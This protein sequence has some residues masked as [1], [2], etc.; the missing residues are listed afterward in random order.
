[1]NTKELV[2]NIRKL[3]ATAALT[4]A[5]L[6]SSMAQAAVIELTR[7]S[8]AF[9]NGSVQGNVQTLGQ[10]FTGVRVGM[11]AFTVTGIIGDPSDVG[12]SL[13]LFDKIAA[14]CIQANVP[15]RNP[16][17]YQLQLGEDYDLLTADQYARVQQVFSQFLGQTGSAVNDAAFQL[18]LW[19][20]IYDDPMLNK[21]LSTGNFQA[22]GFGQAGITAQDWLDALGS[23]RTFQ[24]LWTLRAPATDGSLRASQDLI[25][26]RVP[27]PGALA[28][29]GAGLI[30]FGA[31][32]RRRE[33]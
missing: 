15:L 4:G 5:L 8:P 26:W 22:S 2:M 19:K 9:V 14:F 3:A 13:N 12:L 30:G 11:F 21:D 10:D 31:L 18:V 17:S 27:E 1:M 29:L 23:G 7:S 6:V 32:R 24:T 25:I 33:V 16:A 20:V 28:L